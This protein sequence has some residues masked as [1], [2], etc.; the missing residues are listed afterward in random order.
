MTLAELLTFLGVL[1]FGALVG[2]AI[3]GAFG[4]P[5]G[6][7]LGAV[8]TLVGLFAY[9][10]WFRK[11]DSVH[12]PCRCGRSDWSDFELGRAEGIANVWQCMCGRR[13]SWP[14]W[15]LWFEIDDQGISH[16]FMRRDFLG[17][18]RAVDR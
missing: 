12:P 10:Q 8:A 13:Y 18:W 5:H 1:V 11:A 15:R 6:G 16:Q 2:A 17:R 9:A 3:G 14:K 7:P 4:F